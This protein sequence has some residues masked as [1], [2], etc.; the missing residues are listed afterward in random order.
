MATGLDRF[1]QRIAVGWGNISQNGIK[2]S[3]IFHSTGVPG[4][5]SAYVVPAGG[6][7]A[8]VVGKALYQNTGT[9]AVPVFSLFGGGASTT[10]APATGSTVYAPIT[11]S[12]LYAPITGSTT[13]APIT[14]STAYI[15][16][17]GGT[18]TGSLSVSGSITTGAIYRNYLAVSTG[19]YVV[20]STD[21]VVDFTAGQN[22][23][24]L[25]SA[26]SNKG[27]QFVL[28]NSSTGGWQRLQTA[29]TSQ[30]IDGSTNYYLSVQYAAVM[31]ISDGV[32]YKVI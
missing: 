29:S 5:G 20:S 8:D 19:D 27:Q 15:S 26:T 14:G 32:N 17:T 22:T 11:G 16:S 28:K 13:Y 18:I 6:V 4:A 25:P 21:F 9:T 3:A 1:K 30:F 10:Y 24:T 31:V 7:V 2:A 12:T 23:G